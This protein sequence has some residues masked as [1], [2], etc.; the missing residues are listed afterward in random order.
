MAE[1]HTIETYGRGSYNR[2]I[3][4]HN[5][6]APPSRLADSF[7]C[8]SRRRLP[9]TDEIPYDLYCP[10]VRAKEMDSR[11]CKPHKGQSWECGV[12]NPQILSWGFVDGYRKILQPILHRK[13]S[14]KWFFQEKERSE[15]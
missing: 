3:W 12:A 6:R 5:S 10:S 11:V 4:P 13:Y 7:V 9:T 1:G 14:G 8:F 15:E 2:N